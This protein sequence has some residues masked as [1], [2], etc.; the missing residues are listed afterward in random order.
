MIDLGFGVCFFGKLMVDSC[1]GRK[2]ILESVKSFEK[3]GVLKLRHGGATTGHR[4]G[5]LLHIGEDE[6]WQRWFEREGRGFDVRE[7][8]MRLK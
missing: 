1:R 6:V 8:K 3:R 5:K 2:K 7:R 4:A